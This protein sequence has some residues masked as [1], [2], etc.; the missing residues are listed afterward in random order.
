MSKEHAS[1]SDA[2]TKP[3]GAEIWALLTRAFR[4][5]GGRFKPPA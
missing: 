4:S 1:S 3:A 5:F 2:C